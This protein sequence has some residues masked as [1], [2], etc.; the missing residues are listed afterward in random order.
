VALAAISVDGRCRERNPPDIAIFGPDGDRLIERFADPAEGQALLAQCS[1]GGTAEGV[2]PLL[3]AA[4]SRRFRISLWRQRGGERIRILGAFA[5]I[6]PGPGAACAPSRADPPAPHVLLGES[7]RAPAAAVLAIAGRLRR[8]IEPE[9][10]E[11]APR[12]A[13]ALLGAGWRLMRL[14]DDL[15][16]V[17]ELSP[18][19]LPVH[20][21]EVDAGRLVRRVVDLARAAGAGVATEGAGGPGPLIMSDE[22]ALWSLI[23]RLMAAVDAASGHAARLVVAL[24]RPAS[25]ASLVIEVRAEPAGSNEETVA[26]APQ[27]GP[28]PPALGG[29]SP[30]ARD[31]AAAVAL[32]EATGATVRFLPGPGGHPVARVAFDAAHCL[33]PPDG[34]G[35]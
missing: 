27:G 21:V 8:G 18:P 15:A 14:I 7:L 13:A 28:A 17:E 6:E 11:T 22:G 34:E 30:D 2:A 3:T 12:A 16:L 32:G 4:G 10:G 9:G 26:D 31:R 23:E 25:G 19:R 29:W 33:D 5:A 20:K 35:T 24:D 1:T